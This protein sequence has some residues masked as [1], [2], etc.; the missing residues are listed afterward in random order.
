M[1]S[2]PSSALAATAAPTRYSVYVKSTGFCSY[3]LREREIRQHLETAMY[4]GEILGISCV[5]FGASFRLS[6]LVHLATIDTVVRA[7]SLDNTK[8]EGVCIRVHPTPDTRD[9]LAP[10][11]SKDSSP[12]SEEPNKNAAS[13][14][15][16]KQSDTMPISETNKKEKTQLQKV[17]AASQDKRD[18]KSKALLEAERK[19]QA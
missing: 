6:A 2:P 9:K 13:A 14:A 16:K 19:R 3:P 8:F 10:S 4:P 18:E 11:A 12:T 1:A 15:P 7:C 5:G 17:P